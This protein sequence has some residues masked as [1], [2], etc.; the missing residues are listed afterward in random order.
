MPSAHREH[1]RRDRLP[2]EQPRSRSHERFAQRS[3]LQATTRALDTEHREAELNS[4]PILQKTY[5]LATGHGFCLYARIDL[6]NMHRMHLQC[7]L[8]YGYWIYRS[9]GLRACRIASFP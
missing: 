6:L 9:A 2:E 1:P 8:N 5:G 3:R 4:N 7:I